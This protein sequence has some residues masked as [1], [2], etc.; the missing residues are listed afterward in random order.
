MSRGLS[1]GKAWACFRTKDEH[2]TA[3]VFHM[4]GSRSSSRSQELPCSLW[5][6][7]T[8]IHGDP[9]RVDAGSESSV[10][11]SG[12]YPACALLLLARTRWLA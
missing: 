3:L 5:F 9:F 10:L 1:I 8:G 12:E 11:T 7:R 6:L 2:G 4:Q